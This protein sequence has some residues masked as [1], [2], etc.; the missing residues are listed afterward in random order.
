L[1]APRWA[2]FRIFRRFPQPK[3]ASDWIIEYG[4]DAFG[5][6]GPDSA[7][8]KMAKQLYAAYFTGAAGVNMGLFLIGDGLIVGVDLGGLKYDGTL[9]MAPDGS[10]H[11]AV[12]FVLSPG[13]RLITG[14]AAQG[15]EEFAISVELP[16]NFASGAIVKIDTP[17]GPVNAR[18]EYLR[19]IPND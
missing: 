16:P 15:T 9:V 10:L 8:L 1:E 2:I 19:D 12:S 18:F 5:L 4:S 17:A 11:G 7:R 14:A 3:Q 13:Q 6:K